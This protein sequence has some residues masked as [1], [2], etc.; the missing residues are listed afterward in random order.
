MALIVKNLSFAR[1]DVIVEHALSIKIKSGRCMPKDMSMYHIH[2]RITFIIII[3][4]FFGQLYISILHFNL[5]RCK[6]VV[7]FVSKCRVYLRFS[8]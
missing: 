4:G 8:R 5:F 3:F 6:V 2:A 7:L 1:F